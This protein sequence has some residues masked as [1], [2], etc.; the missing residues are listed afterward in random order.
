M[1]HCKTWIFA[2]QRLP[3]EKMKDSPKIDENKY[4]FL[5][6]ISIG[7]GIEGLI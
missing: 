3:I 1:C 4:D 6:A 5:M 2:H 7:I